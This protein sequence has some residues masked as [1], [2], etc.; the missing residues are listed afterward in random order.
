MKSKLRELSRGII[1]E[2]YFDEVYN[3]YPSIDYIEKDILKVNGL[4]KREENVFIFSCEIFSKIVV[5]CDRCLSNAQYQFE[6]NYDTILEKQEIE[7]FDLEKLVNEEIILNTPLQIICKTDC[8][9]LCV[10]CGT[11]LNISKCDC[12]ND[13]K[14]SPFDIL[15]ELID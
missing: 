1:Q 8:K 4:F 10:T 12:K 7:F 11:N 9:G 5:E 2:F 14:T 3:I 13:Q 15:S 6:L